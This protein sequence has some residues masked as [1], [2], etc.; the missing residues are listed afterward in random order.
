MASESEKLR[1]RIDIGL[2]IL[3]V[4]GSF[5]AGYM[6]AKQQ[7]T[8]F[9]LPLPNGQSSWISGLRYHAG[10]KTIQMF[11]Y[12]VTKKSGY[13]TAGY[14]YPGVSEDEWLEFLQGTGVLHSTGFARSTGKTWWALDFRDRPFVRIA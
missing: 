1:K 2:R 6:T 12:A 14:E 13:K 3:Q 4:L 11:T 9:D 8:W 10:T 5:A 7:G